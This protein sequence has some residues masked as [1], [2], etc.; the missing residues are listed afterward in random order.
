MSDITSIGPAGTTIGYCEYCR[1]YHSY[2]AEMCR[3]MHQPSKVE[4]IPNP[5]Q[6]NYGTLNQ[7]FQC[8]QNIERSMQNI[9]LM[10]RMKQ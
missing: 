2:S 1:C 4:F 10:L 3:D 5:P 7:I 6:F 8:V 9:E